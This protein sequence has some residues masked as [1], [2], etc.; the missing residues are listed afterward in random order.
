MWIQGR[1]VEKKGRG[2]V[3]IIEGKVKRRKEE[4]EN[5]GF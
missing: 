2:E 1:K 3:R 5:L 4:K